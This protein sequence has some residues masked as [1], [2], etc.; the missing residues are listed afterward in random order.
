MNCAGSI[1]FTNNLDERMSKALVLYDQEKYSK[2]S[3]EFKYI[4]K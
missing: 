1:L 4:I 3:E 2:A